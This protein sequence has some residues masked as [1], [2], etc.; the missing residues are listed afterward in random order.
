MFLEFRNASIGYRFPMVENIDASL[1]LGEVCLLMGRNGIGKTTL[2]R[3]IFGQVP[4]HFGD[5]LIDGNSISNLSGREI[6]M[7]VAVVY[8][9]SLVPEHY[10]VRELISLG[11]LMHY[12]YY[13]E[14]TDE[15][16][17]EVDCLISILDLNRY[18]DTPLCRLS[19]GNLQKTFI[20][21]ALFQ[22][23]PMMVLDEPTTYLDEENK[24]EILKLLRDLAKKHHK[25]ILFSCHD[26]RSAREISD[27]AWMIK[28]QKLYS[29]LTEDILYEQGC[30]L[31]FP[32]K[33]DGFI[34]PKIEAPAREKEFL[35]I[36]L[37]K[38]FAENLSSFSF[39]FTENQWLISFQQTVQRA[40]SF[41]EVLD[42]IHSLKLS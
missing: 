21:R 17:N 6:A 12:S 18:E 14:L 38:S 8:S 23:S 2:I 4:L 36:L 19:D 40:G 28:D 20:G 22:G 29:G 33:K 15:D 9:K 35:M 37:Q 1:K 7:R 30:D 31:D 24:H 11:K 42:V 10:T 5:I 3:S 13:F 25:L 39:E 16:K 41:Q 27:K 34:A 32:I 26:W